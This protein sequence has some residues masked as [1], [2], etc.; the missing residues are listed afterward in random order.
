M[1]AQERQLSLVIR[2]EN[3]VPVASAKAYVFAGGDRQIAVGE[4]DFSGRVTFSIGQQ[5]GALSLRIEKVG[6]YGLKIEQ[7]DLDRVEPLELSLLHEQEIQ[8][9]MEVTASPPAIDQTKTAS[10]E[11]IG[12]REILNIPYPT[13]RDF[14]NVLTFIPRVHRD[15]TGQ[16]HIN[17][18]ASYQSFYALDGF[19]I[20]HPSSGL[21]EMRVSPDALRSI[22]VQSSRYSAEYGKASGGVLNLA[23]GMGDDR[24]RFNATDFV[25]S[26]QF[27]RG[28]AL[29]SWTPRVMLT[30]PIHKGRAWFFT[31]ADTDLNLD[32]RTDLPKGADRNESY[33]WST[34]AKGQ[35]NLS[36][37]HIVNAG[38]LVNQFHSEYAGLSLVTPQGATPELSQEAWLFTLKDQIFRANG[39]RIETGVAASRFRSDA[40]PRGTLPYQLSPDRT[41]GNFFK[42]SEVASGRWQGLMNLT[43]SPAQWRGKHEVKMGADINQVLYERQLVRRPIQILRADKTLSREIHFDGNPRTGLDNFEVGVYIQDRWA[44]TNRFLVEAGLRFDRDSIARR[45]LAAPRMAASMLLTEDGETRLAMGLGLFYDASNPDFITR[46]QEGRRV[47]RF[48]ATDGRTQLRQSVETAFT[49]SDRRL[50]APR[51]LGWSMELERKLPASIYMRAEWIG[52]RG[53]NGYAFELQRNVFADQLATILQLTNMR[54]DRYDAFTITARKTFKEN[55]QLF[56]SY[57]RSAARTNAVLDF[58]LDSPIFSSQEG[59]PLDWDAPDRLISWG[60]VPLVKKIDL[61]YSLDWRS[62]YPFSVINQERQLVEDPNSRRFPA[63]FSL[64]LHAERRFRLLGFN[65]ALRAGFNNITNRQNASDVNNNISSPQFLKFNSIQGRTFNGRIRFLGR[66]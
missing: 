3:G 46:S 20:T 55:Y 13:T 52:R 49:L 65:L 34:L 38:V 26:F 19:N 59:G 63:Y 23:T 39:L 17:G 24:L 9:S 50:K 25:P 66:K 10:S 36:P 58:S 4:T 57:T 12:A 45:L 7:V 53:W 41:N 22:E 18:S 11:S 61:A 30:G 35:L 27:I 48:F 15:A 47:D 8:E 5:S 44:I 2:D 60:W 32:I 62:G 40:L 43:L 16:V 64:N 14:R 6:F 37:T 56:A 28:I 21:L 1:P 33:R 42:R 29:N 31:A 54:Q 51:S